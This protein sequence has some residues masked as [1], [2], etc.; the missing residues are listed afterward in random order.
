MR[1]IPIAALTGEGLDSLMGA[2]FESYDAWNMRVRTSDLNRWL[3]RVA[4][5]HTPPLVKGRRVR[6]R[7]MT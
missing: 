2:V 5:Q 3:E 6:L 4:A 7:Y 1:I